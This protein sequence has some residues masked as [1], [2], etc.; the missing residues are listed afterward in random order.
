MDT[1]GMRV[2][3]GDLDVMVTSFIRALRAAN[4]APRTIQAYTEA[5]LQFGAFLTTRGMPTDVAA[6]HREHVESYL[7][8]VLTR[9]KPD[10]RAGSVQEPPGVLPVG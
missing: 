4:K 2:S 1:A 3:V 5:V 8:E 9:W 6:I 10:H 7:E